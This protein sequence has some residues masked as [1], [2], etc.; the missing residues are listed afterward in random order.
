[1][2]REF[3]RAFYSSGA[4]KRCRKD[5][6][7]SVGFW[8]EECLERGVFTMGDEVHHVIALT[9]E[10]I[11]DPNITLNW[12]NLKLLCEKCHKAKLRKKKRF[13][14]DKDGRLVIPEAP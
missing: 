4:W 8:C 5:Y 3:A 13:F 10:N 9:P 7:K 11:N 1:M 12:N 2:R 6:A 14:V